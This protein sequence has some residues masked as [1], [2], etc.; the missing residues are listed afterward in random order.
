MIRL[1]YSDCMKRFNNDPAT[2]PSGY[3]SANDTG[4]STQ[5][6]A[7]DNDQ[8]AS[9]KGDSKPSCKRKGNQEQKG[10]RKRH[11][12][13]GSSEEEIASLFLYFRCGIY[14]SVYPANLQ[15]RQAV[16]PTSQNSDPVIQESAEIRSNPFA[17]IN[18]V[19]G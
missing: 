7:D 15:R 18:A 3:K 5:E 11:R 8:G 13:G 1:G 9:P 6:D 12:N 16:D 10:S 14:Q 4:D 19:A 17:I 2:W